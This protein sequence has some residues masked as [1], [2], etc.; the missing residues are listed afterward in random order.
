MIQRNEIFKKPGHILVSNDYKLE[1]S[2]IY[3][4]W[5]IDCNLELQTTY[6]ISLIPILSK[7]KTERVTAKA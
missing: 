2:W 1:Q 5:D 3:L 7:Q 4:E 6:Q